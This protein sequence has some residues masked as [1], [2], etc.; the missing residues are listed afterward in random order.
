ML[1][2][3]FGGNVRNMNIKTTTI[4]VILVLILIWSSFL[5]YAINYAETLKNHPCNVC[6]KQREQNIYCTH[7]VTG[8]Q[9]IYF[10]GGDI[11]I[12]DG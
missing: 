3:I 8:E 12:E 2:G 9:R 1:H 11:E 10:P 7:Q 4:V 5:I 6:A